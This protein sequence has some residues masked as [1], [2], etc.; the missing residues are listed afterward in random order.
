MAWSSTEA[1]GLMEALTE[2][3]I[4]LADVLN[5]NLTNRDIKDRKALLTCR[6][7][8]MSGCSDAFNGW[9]QTIGN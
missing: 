4:M 6:A 3:V 8:S 7:G 1:Q 2:E 5:V 9:E